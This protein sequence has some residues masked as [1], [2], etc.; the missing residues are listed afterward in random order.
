MKG[1]Y[2]QVC[3]SFPQH[4][5]VELCSFTSYIACSPLVNYCIWLVLSPRRL[6]HPCCPLSHPFCDLLLCCV[7]VHG[8]PGL[9]GSKAWGAV[10]GKGVACVI[11]LQLPMNSIS[12]LSARLFLPLGNNIPDCFRCP[13]T[14]AFAPGGHRELMALSIGTGGRGPEDVAASRSTYKVW[15]E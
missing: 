2:Y 15:S 4:G 13:V 8:V 12:Y 1:K 14:S 3:G 5:N 11:V 10:L 7:G 6:W 9:T